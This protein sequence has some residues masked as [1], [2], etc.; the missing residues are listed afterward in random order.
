M[1]IKDWQKL[2]L[3]DFEYYIVEWKCNWHRGRKSNKIQKLFLISIGS[4]YL[5]FDDKR[6]SYKSIISIEIYKKNS[7]ERRGKRGEN[8]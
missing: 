3:R 2:K 1:K 7:R 4:D 8:V 5:E 6:L